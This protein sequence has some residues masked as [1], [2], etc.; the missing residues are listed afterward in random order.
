[1]SQLSLR[2]PR[3]KVGGLVYFGRMLDKIRLHLRSELPDDYKE[4]FGVALDGRLSQFL[5]LNHR[6]I[7]ERAA[8]GGSDEEILEWCCE[9]G[10]RPNETQIRVWNAY[11]EKLGWR[12]SAA[13]TVAT[14]NERLQSKG[15]VVATIFD[16]IDA[17]EGRFPSG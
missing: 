12:D 2:S 17:G 14:V 15:I 16:C 11:A 3:E 10:L 6:Q 7:S 13:D 9:E 1:M 8:R 4:N 5:C